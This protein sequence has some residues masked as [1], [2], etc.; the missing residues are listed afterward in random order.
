M[1]TQTA[2]MMLLA[3]VIRVVS[4]ASWI[5]WVCCRQVV[6]TASYK[7]QLHGRPRLRA[8]CFPAAV[9]FHSCRLRLRCTFCCSSRTQSASWVEQS[10][11]SE[12]FL[13]FDNSSGRLTAQL[14]R[15]RNV[16]V[17]PQCRL[18]IASIQLASALLCRLP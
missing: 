5:C 6:A 13:C 16:T 11:S 18:V 8:R 3:M 4:V 10:R 12:L 14:S 9:R 1:R 7:L 15:Q 2:V 17:I